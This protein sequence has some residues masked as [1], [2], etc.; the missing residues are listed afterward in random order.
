[1]IVPSRSVG[2]RPEGSARAPRRL[3]FFAIL[4]PFFSD[5]ADCA[6]T[7]NP[8]QQLVPGHEILNASP[9][10]PGVQCRSR[11]KRHEAQLASR[12]CASSI[13]PAIFQSLGVVGV[14]ISLLS[15]TNPSMP[16]H[17]FPLGFS[18]SSLKMVSRRST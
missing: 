6:D 10:D 7:A 11:S 17:F 16:L 5:R 2:G 1:W 9:V 12:S 15:S 18:P 8:A 4:V 13:P 14:I 3:C